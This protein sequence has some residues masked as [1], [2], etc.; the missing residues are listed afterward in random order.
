M[1]VAFKI[2]DIS[3]N[4]NYLLLVA[5]KIKSLKQQLPYNLYIQTKILKGINKSI[6]SKNSMHY[7]ER[8]DHCRSIRKTL[9]LREPIRHNYATST[10]AP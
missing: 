9:I 4:V 7:T 1:Q 2:L 10:Q 3:S 8:M 5:N 6:T